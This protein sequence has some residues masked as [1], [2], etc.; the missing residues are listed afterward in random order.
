MEYVNYNSVPLKQTWFSDAVR[1]DEAGKH[2][3]ALKRVFFAVDELLS[4]GHFDKVDAWL[5]SLTPADFS[6]NLIVG[7]LSITRQAAR[8]LPCREEFFNKS[9]I[10]VEGA[11]RNAD[12]LLNGLKRL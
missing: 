5:S 1:D 12:K 8:H 7:V 9:W 10:V 3:Q 11:G 6:V 4:R 2:I